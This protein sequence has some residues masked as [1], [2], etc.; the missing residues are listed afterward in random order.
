MKEFLCKEEQDCPSGS[1]ML[2]PGPL[3][4]CAKG[5]WKAKVHQKTIN[6]CLME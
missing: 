3:A 1:V 4:S 2:V 5:V 6:C